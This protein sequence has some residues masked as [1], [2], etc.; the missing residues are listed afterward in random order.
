[1]LNKAPIFINGFTRG[2]TNLIMNLLASHPEVSILSGETQEVF[3]GTSKRGNR[4][5][6]RF[7]YSP[8]KA[9]AGQHIF[10][11]HSFENRK[12]IPRAMM[13]YIDLFFYIDKLA[14]ERN[15]FKSEDSRY[16]LRE[17]NRTRFLAKNIN[18]VVFASDI[19]AEMYPDATFIAIVRNGLAIC[20][21]HIRRGR[22]ADEFG[23]MYEAVC[24]KMIQDSTL[25]KNYHIVYFEDMVADPVGFMKKI[26]ALANLDI[27][28]VSKVRL[29]AKKSMG[30]DG[31]RQYTFGGEKDRE[32]HWF[33]AETI[34]NYIRKEVNES[35]IRR[36]SAED[37]D[38]FL[39]QAQRS[40]EDLGY[41]KK[42]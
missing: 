19:F 26:Y 23:Q 11:T 12:S 9:A 8:V 36:L 10:Q 7:F 42:S 2:G 5:I 15:T 22:T 14:T 35:Q 24:R 29:Q 3:C 37:R 33:G 17:L 40:M 25:R 41:L 39:K 38:A 28:K 20:E 18:G 27:A 32:T 34:G 1:M 31:S 16:S 4:K 21:G 30:E 13:H 6:R